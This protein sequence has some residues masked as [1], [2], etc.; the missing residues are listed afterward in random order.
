MPN[1]FAVN[2]QTIGFRIDSDEQ[3]KNDG[4]KK[5]LTTMPINNINNY[6]GAFYNIILENLNRQTLTDDDW[7]R[8]VSISDGRITP[9]IKKLSTQ[10]V[11]TLTANG[12]VAAAMFL[13]K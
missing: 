8:T 7:K 2:H 4:T 9:R 6:L 13:I 3:I 12:Q 11:Q 5:G 10:E 1:K